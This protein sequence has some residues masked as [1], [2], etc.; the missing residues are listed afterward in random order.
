MLLSC[1]RERDRTPREIESRKVLA[2]GEFGLW[3]FPVQPA[4]DHQ[5]DHEP[6]ISVEAESDPF[7][8][9]PQ[10]AD[11]SAFH[12][13]NG[14]VGGPEDEWTGD[15]HSLKRLARDSVFERA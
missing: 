11:G 5:V 12:G 13:G 9:A 14:R 8:D 2:S 7:S 10:T 6:Q 15:P 4:R 1:L 3:R